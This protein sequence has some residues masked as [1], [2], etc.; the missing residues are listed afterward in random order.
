MI[1]NRL[2]KL[3]KLAAT[4][5]VEHCGACRDGMNPIVMI[6]RG[7]QGT[8]LE[9]F[10]GLPSPYD[11]GGRCRTCDQPAQEHSRVI[12]VRPRHAVTA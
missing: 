2:A 10:D 4:A 3:E 12:L 1:R 7:A 5:N 8:A 11:D 6:Q 9:R